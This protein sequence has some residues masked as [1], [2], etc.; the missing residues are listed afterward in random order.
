MKRP[1]QFLPLLKQM[2]GFYRYGPLPLLIYLGI[3][4]AVLVA[5]SVFLPVGWMEAHGRQSFWGD[6]LFVGCCLWWFFLILVSTPLPFLVLSGVTSLEF[7]FTRAVDRAIWLRTERVAVII[8]ALGPL[9][10][11]LLLSPLGP[12][13]ALEP[14]APG[15]SAALAQQ[16]YL[17][18]FPG[19]H[20]AAAGSSTQAGQLVIRHGT[21][22]LAAW[23]VWLGLVCVCLVAAYFALVFPAWQRAG[24]H[25]SSS[26]LR[27]WVGAL[28][29]NAPAFLPIALLVLCAFLRFNI[30]E[31]SFLLFACHPVLLT[32]ALLG[33]IFAVQPL[34]ERSI[35]KLE[36]EFS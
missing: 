32:I 3:T 13:L 21:E 10:L 16:R 29:V 15:S 35:R 36:F 2:L 26:K 5:S 17:Q 33:L 25:H 27:P 30:L 31:E 1:R 19:S 22:M 34:S 4:A 12:A 18:A 24:W 20:L 8:I 7:L 14:A 6:Q 11:N 28:M 9:I 23:M